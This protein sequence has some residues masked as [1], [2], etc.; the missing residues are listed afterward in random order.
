MS[1]M[2]IDDGIDTKRHWSL[3]YHLDHF[4]KEVR[5]RK[6]LVKTPF[7]ETKARISEIHFRHEIQIKIRN[8]I[9]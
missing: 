4:P 7:S 5:F 9:L 6:I 2:E 3:S 1:K 8:E